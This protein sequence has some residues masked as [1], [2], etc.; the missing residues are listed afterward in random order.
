MEARF[1]TVRELFNKPGAKFT[2]PGYQRGFEWGKKE[3]EDL[4]L[5][6]NRI[7]R[8]VDRHYLGNII[9]LEK[10]RGET[11]EI[12]DGQQRMVTLS[13]LLMAIRDS[14]VVGERDDKRVT[15]VINSYP[16]ADPEQ[17]IILHD[18]EAD[19]SFRKIWRGAVDEATGPV[20]V[21][22]NYYLDQ[23]QDLSDAEIDNLTQNIVTRLE[24]VETQCSDVSLAYTI[25]QSQNERGKEVSPHILVKSR[26]YGAAEELESK[27]DRVQAKR[28]W[29]HIYD[30][31]QE[32]LGGTRW[33]NDEMKVRRPMSQILLSADTDM[34]FR[35]DKSDLYRNFEEVLASYDNILE[36]VEWFQD[37]VDQ[38]LEL[39]SG[40]Y[41]VS[42]GGYSN[43]TVRNLQYM[44]ASSTQAE[45]L[46]QSL[47][48]RVD[49][50]DMLK[51]YLRLASVIGMRH[52]LAGSSAKEKD[53]PMFKSA[54]RVREAEN[55]KAIRRVLREMAVEETP[56][57][58]EIVQNL[59]SN[60]MNYHGAWQFRTLLTLVGLEENRQEALRVE[61]GKLH[62]EHIAPRRLS[63][64]SKYS[65]WRRVIDEDEFDG[66]KNLLGNLTLLL[67]EEHGSLKEE[68]FNSKRAAY[69]NSDLEIAE[70]VSDYE[71]WN[72][73][74]IRQRT[75]R[76][77]QEA[78]DVWSA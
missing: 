58:G 17:R 65:R 59:K 16:K 29:D 45:V 33:R 4:W 75:E 22:Y 64:D 31:L 73:E 38:Y 71:E 51:E 3:F 69:G 8:R 41:D 20:S 67:P 5:D 24:V 57:D 74:N 23:L 36:L 6:I 27:E 42:G 50:E 12:V 15:Q 1:R 43:G 48:R 7:G 77:A 49:D 39:T 11:F 30:L 46:S 10:E 47:C 53:D 2:V 61:L 25:F 70:E 34:P 52:E 26:V 78:A 18:E 19:E 40:Q 28:R 68:N 44:N 66:V 55:N 60:P 9:L 76:L 13:L 35:I 56:D 72:V 37:E 32:E 21:A 54:K 14:M 62:I 63:E